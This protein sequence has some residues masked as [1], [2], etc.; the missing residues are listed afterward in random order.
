[1]VKKARLALATLPVGESWAQ[2]TAVR[3]VLTSARS[4]QLRAGQLASTSA[5]HVSRAQ[6]SLQLVSK[7]G[8]LVNSAAWDDKMAAELVYSQHASR[9]SRR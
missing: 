7:Y 4:V 3:K 2:R 8:E 9:L 6:Q 5:P 1:M